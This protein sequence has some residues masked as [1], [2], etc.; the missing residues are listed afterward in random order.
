MSPSGVPPGIRDVAIAIVRDA[1]GVLRRRAILERLEQRGHRIS[2][3]GLNRLLD[4]TR[5]SGWTEETAEGVRLLR[6]PP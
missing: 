3:A 1:G 2:L 4:E 5:R 6:P